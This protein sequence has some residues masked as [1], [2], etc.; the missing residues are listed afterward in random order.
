[1]GI[2]GDTKIKIASIPDD[3]FKAFTYATA[4]KRNNHAV[5]ILS[6]DE[7]LAKRGAEYVNNSIP[8]IEDFVPTPEQQKCTATG[9]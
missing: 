1:M 2:E 7:L 9:D 5:K 8:P 4:K 3:F 6:M